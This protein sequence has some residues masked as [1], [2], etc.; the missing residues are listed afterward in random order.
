[1]EGAKYTNSSLCGNLADAED[2]TAR[3]HVELWNASPDVRWVARHVIYIGPLRLAFDCR[4]DELRKLFFA[5][6]GLGTSSGL[7]AEPTAESLARLVVA[8]QPREALVDLNMI[9][10]GELADLRDRAE[11]DTED[12]LSVSIRHED[13]AR[14]E[15]SLAWVLVQVGLPSAA[16]AQERAA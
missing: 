11:L 4:E 3:A 7:E 8:L 6:K 15:R 14:A 2:K 16:E 5:L 9:A 10:S 1:M 12:P 13:A